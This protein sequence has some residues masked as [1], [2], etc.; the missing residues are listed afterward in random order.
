MNSV[1]GDRQGGEREGDG[2]RMPRESGGGAAQ[3]PGV[4][5]GTLSVVGGAEGEGSVG[6]EISIVTL[7]PS[8]SKAVTTFFCGISRSKLQR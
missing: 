5:P 4:T 6:A 7:N 2:P 1:F 8:S 3:Q